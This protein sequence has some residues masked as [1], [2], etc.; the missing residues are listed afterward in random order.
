MLIL[1]SL[2]CIIETQR[3]EIASLKQ[4]VQELR[5]KLN[6]LILMVKIEWALTVTG[7]VNI[8]FEGDTFFFRL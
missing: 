5:D 7:R 2:L 8:V 4:T 3:T 1:F 6:C